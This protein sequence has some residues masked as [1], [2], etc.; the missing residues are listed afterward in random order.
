M[1]WMKGITGA[2]AP[3]PQPVLQAQ[4]VHSIPV[5][6]ATPLATSSAR[7]KGI[8]NEKKDS[9]RTNVPLETAEA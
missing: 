4:R 7:G 1:P 9:K 6:L 5:I 3:G 8:R 2:G